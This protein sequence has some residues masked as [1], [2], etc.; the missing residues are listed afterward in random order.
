MKNVNELFP[1]GGAQEGK[2]V[3]TTMGNKTREIEISDDEDYQNRLRME[4][5]AMMAKD[6]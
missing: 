5:Q 3:Q 1:T 4:E 2:G 6:R